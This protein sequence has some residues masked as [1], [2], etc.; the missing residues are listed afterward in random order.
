MGNT[1][2]DFFRAVKVEDGKNSRAFYTHQIDAIRAMDT[3]NKKES[4]SAILV[5]P[6]GARKT[7]TATSWLLRNAVDQS[8]KVL[9]IAHRY[10]LLEKA[11]Q[12]FKANAYS[13]QMVQRS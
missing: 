7:M 8:I 6:T 10:L 12:A 9:W 3:L 11:A 1:E 2:I 13:D 5:L 4:F